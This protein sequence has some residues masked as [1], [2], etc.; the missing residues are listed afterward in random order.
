V[1]FL[2]AMFRDWKVEPQRREGESFA[3]ARTRVLDFVE[4]DS[5]YGGLLLQ[6]MHPEKV[7][8]VW[9]RR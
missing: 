1:A 5:G 8:L 7:P 9:S 6:L 4:A 3:E 2:A